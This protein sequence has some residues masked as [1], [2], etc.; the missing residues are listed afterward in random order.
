MDYGWQTEEESWREIPKTP[1]EISNT[2][3]VRRWQGKTGKYLILKPEG[4]SVR[5][6]KEKKRYNIPKMMVQIWGVRFVSE[7]SGEEW[8][9]IK[10]LEDA[11]QVSNLGRIRSKERYIIRKDGSQVYMHERIIK[12]TRINS[13]YM[14]VN[15][16]PGNKVLYHK[17]VHRLVAEHFIPNPD[18][19]EQVNHKDENKQ[20]NEASN[21]EWCT[22]IYNS[23]YGTNQAR[24]IA[25]RLKNNG[26]KYGV[27]RRSNRHSS[28]KE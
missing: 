17:L 15:L 22:R 2:G 23:V 1:Y 20:N 6:T 24:R 21:L 9:D 3:R 13:G 19:L 18:N 27:Q 11:Y 4:N 5:L 26:G 10:G 7:D 28:I 8:V 16:R 14:A 25:T 12:P